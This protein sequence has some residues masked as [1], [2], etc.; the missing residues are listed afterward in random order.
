MRYRQTICVDIF[1]DNMEEEGRKANE[2]VM[3]LPNSFQ[4]ELTRFPHGSNISLD[5]ENEGKGA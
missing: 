1:V 2:N 5:N 4:V 3:K